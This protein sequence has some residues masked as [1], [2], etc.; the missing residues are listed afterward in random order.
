[1]KK[2]TKTIAILFAMFTML[3]GTATISNAAVVN[4]W[5][6][7][8]EGREIV[9][10]YYQNSKM[11]QNQ[12]LQVSQTGL[13]YYFDYEGV[14]VTG[15]GEDEVTGYYFDS[16]GA[17]A[18]GWKKLSKTT[19]SGPASGS[20]NA[21]YYFHS[22]GEMATGWQYLGNTWYYFS[23]GFIDGFGEGEMVYGLVDIDGEYYYF[24]SVDQG[25]MKTG[26]QTVT[27]STTVSRPGGSSTSNK[28]YFF[29]S[30]GTMR[31]DGWAKEGSYWYYFEDDGLMATGSVTIDGK[32]FYLDPSTGRM[33][34]GWVLV[35]ASQANSPTASTGSF[36]QFYNDD[37]TLRTGWVYTGGK[38]YY[39]ATE[40]DIASSGGMSGKTLGEMAVG[41]VSN[42]DNGSGT[43]YFTTSGSLVQNNWQ[44]I[45]GNRYYFGGDGKRYEATG[46]NDVLVQTISSRQYAFDQNGIMLKSRDIYQV[47]SNWS[48]TKPSSGTYKVAT[49]S[50]SGIVGTAK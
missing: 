25:A 38:W 3:I 19:S 35:K 27:T 23:D 1:M 21:W 46:V 44:T 8:Q 9:W 11:M 45:D 17:M 39:L 37:G 12:W 2:T 43:F 18:T 6:Q 10:R 20:S 48:L 30:N 7:S 5:E 41:L 13:W 42:I 14:M 49:I 24:G 15:W 36:Y 22:S 16:S 47:G 50:S 34:T 29:E 40:K 33:Q 31:R 32:N 4:G 26:F 28:T